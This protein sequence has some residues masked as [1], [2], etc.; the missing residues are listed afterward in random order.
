MM[1]CI[2]FKPVEVQ[3]VGDAVYLAEW[4]RRFQVQSLEILTVDALVSSV[5]KLNFCHLLVVSDRQDADRTKN[6]DL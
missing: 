6:K 5:D 2:Y 1:K 3:S 4:A